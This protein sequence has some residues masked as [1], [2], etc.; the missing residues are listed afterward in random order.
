MT[1]PQKSIQQIMGLIMATTNAEI[2][3]KLWIRADALTD[4]IAGLMEDEIVCDA[5]GETFDPGLDED[6][7][8]SL[9]EI[10]EEAEALDWIV[11]EDTYCPE[12]KGY[13]PDHIESD[14]GHPVLE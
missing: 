8:M 11:E 1:D 5:C 12:H 7:A 10:V 14:Y 6:D 2:Q 4:K 13:R 9:A 3:D